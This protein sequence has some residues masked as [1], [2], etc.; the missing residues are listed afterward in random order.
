L[1]SN[2]PTW[3]KLQD[4]AGGEGPDGKE[5]PTRIHVEQTV[6]G[7]WAAG[8]EIL[9]T[10]H[11]RS[12]DEHQVRT[13]KS[14][15]DVSGGLVEIEL[16]HP[17]VRPTTA[18]DPHPD[19]DIYAVEVALL[20]RNIVFEGGH[21][22]N[23]A[24]GGHFIVTN[25]PN[26]PQV[27]QGVD[28]KNFGQQ[29]TL[30]RYPIHFHFCGDVE[31]SVVSKNTIR[32]SNQRCV[33]VHGTNK[34]LIENN[35][36]Y[37]TKGHCYL[38]EDGMERDNRFIRNIGAQTG[39]PNM[40][41]PDNG[42]NGKETDDEPSTFWITSPRN[43]FE[44]NVAAGSEHSG[45]WLE[46]KLRGTRADEFPDLDPMQE[47]LISF[48]NNV[49]HSNGGKNVSTLI[50]EI[51]PQKLQFLSH[52]LPCITGSH[53]TLYARLSAQLTSNDVWS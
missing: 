14:L 31:N 44:D 9:I 10:S 45:I 25:T 32:Q 1:P 19:C 28:V 37:D 5:N 20:S 17:I 48:K 38:T 49:A 6:K 40:I 21:D 42:F 41:I 22:S 27:F 46:P 39:A 36:A 8:A 13:I 50:T 11:T 52:F 12:W 34:L 26:V 29:G 43:T 16:S 51:P 7:K 23:S 33:V 47:P 18:K 53:S 3:L 24:H 4:V 15:R 35:V 2:T 30:G